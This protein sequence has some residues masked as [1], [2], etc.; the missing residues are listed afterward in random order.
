MVVEITAV[1]CTRNRAEFL[2]KCLKSLLV[3]S[4]SRDCFEILVV[5]NGST[6]ATGDVLGR[7]AD[8]QGIRIIDEPIVGLSR[9]RNTAWQEARGKFVGYIDDDAV[10]DSIWLESALGSF[11]GV[12][13]VPDWVGG[14]IELEWEE[15]NPGWITE[16]LAVPLGLVHWGNTP[17]MIRFP[18]RL[19]GGNSFFTR[20]RLRQLG[21]FDERLGRGGA[22]LLSG[23]ETQLQLR[24][25]AADGVQ[26]R[27]RWKSVRFHRSYQPPHA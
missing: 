27:Y 18:Q 15:P 7:Y 13:P 4:L 2:D 3:Q 9:A 20:D 23:E 14:P 17:R 1:I 21:G 24:F 16:E 22:G 26:D 8:D 25:E 12:S 10:A 19:G 11:C 6:D 5:N